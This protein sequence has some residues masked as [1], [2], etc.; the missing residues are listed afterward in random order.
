MATQRHFGP[1]AGISVGKIFASRQ[2]LSTAKVHRPTQAGISGSGKDG[3]DSIVLNGGYAD[4]EDHGDVIVYT[5]H[6]GRDARGNQ[7]QD[8][9]ITDPGN[10]GLKISFEDQLPV[11]VVRGFNGDPKWSPESGYRY[12]GL[13]L[14]SRFWEAIGFDGYKVCRY[15]L[16]RVEQT[17]VI[18]AAD[19]TPVDRT[20]IVAE[21]L[22]RNPLLAQRLKKTYDWTC[23]MCGTRIE[24]PSGPYAE[25]AHIKP[26]GRPDDGPDVEENMLCLCPNHHKLLDSGGVVVD[27]AWNIFHLVE[28]KNVGTLARKPKHKL[29]QQFLEWHRERWVGP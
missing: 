28:N 14:V 10:A 6:G 2:E 4:D 29:T 19:G 24:S 5:G 17:K 22:I 7:V 23:Q 25:A 21:R 1:I 26:L 27:E 18:E 20:T 11:R 8:Q 13:Y 3:S 12:D 15:L 9:Q 16:D